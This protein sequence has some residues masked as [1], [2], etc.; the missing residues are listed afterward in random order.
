MS[1]PPAVRPQWGVL[2]TA[3]AAC[4][5]ASVFVGVRLVLPAECAWLPPQTGVFTAEGVVPRTHVGCPLPQGS[6]VTGVRQVGGQL[7]ATI[8]PG[9]SEIVLALTAQSGQLAIQGWR[10]GGTLLF[11]TALFT[12]TGVAIKRRPGDPAAGSNL[13]FASALLGSTV[14]TVVG[15]P[16]SWAFE[17]PWG[18]L[19]MINVGLLYTL[20]WSNMLSWSLQ[21]PSPMAGWLRR[22]WAAITVSWLPPLLWTSLV[23]I[24]SAGQPFHRWMARAVDLQHGFTLACLGSALGV[25]IVRLV[26]AQRPGTDP[27][28]RQQLL[29]LG[30]SAVISGLL[31]L[32]L[33]IVPTLFTGRALLPEE[34]IGLPGLFYVAGMT[35]AMLRYR[36]FDLDVVLGRTLVFVALTAVA[37]SAYLLTVAVL[38]TLVADQPTGVAVAGAVAVAILV[39]PVRVRLERWVSRALYGDRDDPYV[40]LARLAGLLS[41]R[42]VPWSAVTED[43]RRALRVP[44]VSVRGTDPAAG[45]RTVAETGQPPDQPGRLLEQ[46]LTHAGEAVGELV[47]ATRGRSERFSPAERRLL[48]DLGHQ[49]AVALHQERLDREVRTSR[50]RLVLAREEE[51]KM[52]RRTLHDDLGPTIASIPLRIETVRRGMQHAPPEVLESLD[53]IGRDATV[54]ADGVRRLAYDLRPPVLDEL[55]LTRALSELASGLAPLAVDLEIDGLDEAEPL[56]A[57]VEAAAY[58]I[59]AGALAN[60]AR[61]AHARAASVTLRRTADALEIDIADDGDGPAADARSGVGITAMRERADEL[62]GW[63]TIEPRPGGGT[64]VR[65]MLPLGGDHE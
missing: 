47:I 51:R 49:V 31:A 46:P 53:R 23:L 28:Q 14:V 35:V 39:N 41:A 62:G 60:T 30:G 1:S 48:Q 54:A 25:V 37:I 58:R 27:V 2:I 43:L 38:T 52:L 22:R 59:A 44:Y 50:E 15:L 61:H 45:G 42:Q 64:M 7:A 6:L 8:E 9:P 16:P 21:F 13:V 65:A 63:C 55:G 32:G 3:L 34:S 36:L 10:A 11:V 20:A 26:R 19:F 40:A 29:W 57:A 17:G 12:L 33:W 5:C 18:W 4:L 24:T 56:P